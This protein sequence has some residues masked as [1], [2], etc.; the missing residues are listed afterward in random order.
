MMDK[1]KEFGH[2]D[3]VPVASNFAKDD[4]CLNNDP[5]TLLVGP[6]AVAV[7]D[8]D[9]YLA[10]LVR[11]NGKAM[12]LLGLKYKDEFYEFYERRGIQIRRIW[13]FF[14]R[15]SLPLIR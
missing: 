2:M 4:T 9:R 3:P 13:K 14:F 12:Y 10:T 8:V 6:S 1:V 15:L 11:W 7:D 5:T